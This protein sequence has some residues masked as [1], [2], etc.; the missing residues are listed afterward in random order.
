MR[1]I[2]E[3]RKVRQQREVV[4]LPRSDTHWML[5]STIIVQL[6]VVCVCVCV[7]VCVSKLYHNR[8]IFILEQVGDIFF[9]CTQN[10]PGLG[11]LL[12]CHSR[13]WLGTIV[14]CQ[15][16][17]A[18]LWPLFLFPWED[19]QVSHIIGK[20]TLFF[21]QGLLEAEAGQGTLNNG[22]S[23]GEQRKREIPAC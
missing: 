22:L 15:P 9:G 1:G 14:K 19:K 21:S 11:Q 3:Q 16:Y 23:N 6:P 13:W 4:F 2:Y 8:N 20:D 5:V 18:G 12:N 17:G 10:Q 7:C